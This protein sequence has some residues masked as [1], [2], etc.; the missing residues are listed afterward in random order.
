MLVELRVLSVNDP[1]GTPLTDEQRDEVLAA[2]PASV[3]VKLG[4]EQFRTTSYALHLA[5]DTIAVASIAA[6]ASQFSAG[7]FG[8]MGMDTWRG[9]RRGLARLLRRRN[10]AQY[11][12]QGRAYVL[13]NYDDGRTV[14]LQSL[15]VIPHSKANALTDQQVEDR[16][17]ETLDAY[18]ERKAEIGRLLEAAARPDRPVLFVQMINHQPRV[19]AYRSLSDLSR[20]SLFPDPEDRSR[21][22][23]L[24]GPEFG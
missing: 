1:G 24:F 5:V 3:E 8:Q 16:L 6:V 10:D 9:V 12:T 13:L 20:N 2:F 21:D 19:S 7:F 17:A 22:H 15:E 18:W 4:P 23:K 11:S 14:V